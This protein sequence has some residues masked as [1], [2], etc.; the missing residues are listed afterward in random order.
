MS[1]SGGRRA[2][3]YRPM[4][5]R[6]S[7]EEGR[8]AT[9]LELLFDLSFVVAIAQLGTQLEH[10]VTEEHYG[11]GAMGF[12]FTFFAIWWAWMN[13][14]W[15]ASAYDTDDVPYR[16]ATLVQIAGVLVLAAGV[17]RAFSGLD[18]TVPILGYAVMRTALIAQWLRA[19]HQ[20]RHSVRRHTALRYAG[21]ITVAEAGWVAWLFMPDGWQ[22]WWFLLLVIVE[23]AVPAYAEHYS[24]TPWHAHHISERYGLFTIIV[25]GESITAATV[26]IQEALDGEGQARLGDLAAVVVG[27]LLIM[28]AM[29]WQYFSVPAHDLVRH[30]S[31]RLLSLLAWGYGHVLVFAGAAAVGPGLVVAANQALATNELDARMAAAAVGLPTALYVLCVEFLQLRP[32]QRTPLLRWVFPACAVLVLAAVFAPQPVLIMGIVM[33]LAVGVAVYGTGQTHAQEQLVAD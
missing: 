2:S 5:G 13:F 8:T 6:D 1:E 18:F 4:R 10:A 17:P 26:G 21:G 9:P 32:Y 11:L 15:F 27:G 23:L 3:W 16:C 33:S 24:L 31:Q 30:R 25:L 14:T 12:V 22:L 7:S 20:A 19:A 29:W 28:F